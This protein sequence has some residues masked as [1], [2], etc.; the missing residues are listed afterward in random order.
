MFINLM[1]ICFSHNQELSDRGAKST[2]DIKKYKPG[3]TWNK[4]G[5]L[6]EIRI[7]FQFV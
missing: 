4:G 3:Y 6:K 5:R 7:R 1:F 2:I